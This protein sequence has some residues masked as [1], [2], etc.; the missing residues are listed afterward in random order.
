MTL[1]T[2][3]IIVQPDGTISV[4]EPLP[5]GEH[6]ARVEIAGTLTPPAPREAFDPS[7]FPVFDMGPWPEGLSLRRE[8]MYGD[9]GR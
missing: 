6:L 7:K 8:D 4:A 1:I 9:D 2:T 5:V 3:L